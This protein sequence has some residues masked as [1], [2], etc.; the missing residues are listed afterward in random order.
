LFLSYSTNDQTH[1]ENLT[2]V[3]AARETHQKKEP[4]A[5]PYF[6]YPAGTYQDHKMLPTSFQLSLWVQGC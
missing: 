6:I 3:C 5:F 4:P 1:E 2:D